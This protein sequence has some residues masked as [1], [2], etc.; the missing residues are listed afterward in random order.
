MDIIE[1]MKIYRILRLKCATD[2]TLN[3][4]GTEDQTTIAWFGPMK[5]FVGFPKSHSLNED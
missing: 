5:C 1:D 2:R 3:T 4:K